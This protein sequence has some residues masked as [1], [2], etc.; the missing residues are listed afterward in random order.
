MSGSK[1]VGKQA[2]KQAQ[3]KL[4]AQIKVVVVASKFAKALHT[5]FWRGCTV[6]M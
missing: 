6:T 1:C 3:T 5:L 4:Q 2:G